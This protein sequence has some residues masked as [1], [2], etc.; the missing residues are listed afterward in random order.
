MRSDFRSTI[1]WQPDVKTDA[2]GTATVK[3]KYPDSLTTWS[4]RRA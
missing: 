3:V 2:D 1:L 4:R